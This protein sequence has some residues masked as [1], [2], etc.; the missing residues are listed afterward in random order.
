M[1]KEPT[2]IRIANVQKPVKIRV[3]R[4]ALLRLE[5]DAPDGY[6]TNRPHANLTLVSEP[7]GLVVLDSRSDFRGGRARMTVRA[8]AKAR[9]GDK[10]KVTVFLFTSSKE[11]F[12][13]RITF[14]IE[15]AE[16]AP[17]AGGTSKSKVQV[18]EPIPVYQKGDGGPSWKDLGW[19][20]SSVAEVHADGRDTK[21]YVNMDGR[22]IA[23]L[24][25]SAGYQE[26]GLKRMKNSYLLY[27]GFYAY[28]QDVSLRG[29]KLGIEGKEFEDYVTGEL[30]RVSQTV[31]HTISAA[32]RLE[33]DEE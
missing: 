7:D 20:E 16:E 32:G 17:S 21:I 9:T 29:K 3:D 27:A 11:S 33:G 24:L 18:P 26:V 13:A 15:E 1:K 23:R 8:T 30:D 6:L 22:H 19:N 12:A 25:R 28:A 14:A 2:F 5:S 4:S 31:V 10:G